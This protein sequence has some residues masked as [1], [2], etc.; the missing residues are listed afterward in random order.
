MFVV[1]LLRSVAGPLLILGLAVT[2][3]T[4]SSACADSYNCEGTYSCADYSTS[5]CSQEQAQG[6]AVGPACVDVPCEG[7]KTQAQCTADRYCAWEGDMS[8]CLQ[9]SG[10]CEYMTEAQC[11]GDTTCSWG[12]ACLGPNINCMR[13][14][15]VGDC[16]RHKYCSWA[17]LPNLN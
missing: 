14:G 1:P 8:R 11:A 3:Q 7:F 10:H 6:C 17:R 9:Q 12:S 5:E 15:N 16:Q 2:L 13:Y 4:S